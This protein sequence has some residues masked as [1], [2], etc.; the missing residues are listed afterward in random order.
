MFKF[1]GVKMT[2]SKPTHYKHL[3]GTCIVQS[4][5]FATLIKFDLDT[6]I[7]RCFSMYNF[8]NFRKSI[9]INLKW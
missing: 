4:N 1:K 9:T 7:S 5:L 3:E 6:H 2:L 8:A